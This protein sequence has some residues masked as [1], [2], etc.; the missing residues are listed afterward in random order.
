MN[1][2]GKQRAG[3]WKHLT[4]DCSTT[5]RPVVMGPIDITKSS[6]TGS[7][8]VRQVAKRTLDGDPTR[9][10]AV[11]TMS[12]APDAMSANFNKQQCCQKAIPSLSS[13]F[14]TGAFQLKH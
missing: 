6:H 9:V 13:R 8:L 7:G 10:N 14:I 3:I 5:G 2:H 1:T 12:F 4:F 11:G